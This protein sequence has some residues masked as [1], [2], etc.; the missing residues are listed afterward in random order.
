LEEAELSKSEGAAPGAAYLHLKEEVC[1]VLV[2][3]LVHVEFEAT[4]LLLMIG[5]K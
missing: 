3:R 1:K 2:H 5:W 4:C